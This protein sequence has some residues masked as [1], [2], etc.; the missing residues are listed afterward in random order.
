MKLPSLFISHGPPTFA[1]EPGEAG[2]RLR[3]LGERLPR[4]KAIVILSPHWQTS[5]PKVS[6]TLK[7]ETIHDFGGFPDALYE[8]KY[9]PAGDPDLAYRMIELLRLDGWE[10]EADST[11]GLD[12]GAW[13]PLLHMYPAVDVPVVQVSMPQTL[14]P[15]SALA[16]G[17]SLA[18]LADEGVLIIGS[19]SLTHN[20]SEHRMQFKQPSERALAFRDYVHRALAAGDEQALLTALDDAPNAEWAHPTSE[21]FLPLL[22]VAGAAAEGARAE[23]IDGGFVNG[24]LSMDSVRFA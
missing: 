16:M 19:G 10:A 12:H 17:Q 13:V 7:H 20:L 14:T 21:H 9:E 8:L 5:V 18:P 24:V 6:N 2:A 11:R 23:I 1:L 15:K 4:P 3:E 22:F